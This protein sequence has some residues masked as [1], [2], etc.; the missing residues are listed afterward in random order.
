MDKQLVLKLKLVALIFLILSVAVS[1]QILSGIMSSSAGG[2]GSATYQTGGSCSNGTTNCTV[3]VSVTSGWEII[4]IGDNTSNATNSMSDTN[5]D[6]FSDCGNGSQTYTVG[7]VH[8]AQ[9]FCATFG[10]TNASE[11]ITFTSS[12]N[13]NY[14]G[15][16]FV[17]FSGGFNTV[18]KNASQVSVNSTGVYSSGATAATTTASENVVGGCAGVNAGNVAFTAGTGFTFSSASSGL[19]GANLDIL[20]MDYMTVSSTGAQTMLMNNSNSTTSVDA[21]CFVVTL[22]Q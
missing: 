3:T 1:A 22:H 4:G 2:G 8:V 10:T 16:T 17:I 9:M 6:I 14:M 20:G 21:L 18:D 11:V 19:F 15:G 7:I 5:G 13:T 12:L